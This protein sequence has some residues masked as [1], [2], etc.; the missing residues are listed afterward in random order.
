[1]TRKNFPEVRA[2][3]GKEQE[4]LT[5]ALAA[6]S[7]KYGITIRT[8]CENSEFAKF[9][10]DVSGPEVRAVTGK[11]QEILTE[12]LAAISKKY[13]ITIRT[14]C[15]NS[16]FAKFGVDVSGCI[17]NFDGSACCNQ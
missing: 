4:I 16:E 7:K 13:G 1:M 9:G 12:A 2:V 5:E 10:V 17:G 8:C 11:E 15:E 6:I 3:T 14:C